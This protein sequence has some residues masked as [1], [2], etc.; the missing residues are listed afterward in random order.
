MRGGALGDFILTTPALRALGAAVDHLTVCAHPRFAALLGDAAPTGWDLHGTASL[1]LFC[2]ATPPQAFDGAVV[3]TPGVADRLRQYGVPRVV[4]ASPTPPSGHSALTHLWAPVARLLDLEG[5]PPSPWLA[6]T[7]AAR[8][9]LAALT[10]PGG[11]IVLAPG[12]ASAA[13]RWGSFPALA[14]HLVQRGFPVLWAPGRDEPPLPAGLPGTVL[15]VLDLDELLALAQRCRA[16]VGNDTGTTHLAAAAGAPVVAL[17][18]PT[19]PAVWAPRGARVLPLSSSVERVVR[20]LD[21][22]VLAPVNKE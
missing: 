8:R 11:A 12:A 13:K 2:D 1:W 14:R 6:P 16:W 5:P 20:E 10:E 19:D 9:R 7:P 22:A 21:Y 4:S 17:F 3:W 15:P 18:G